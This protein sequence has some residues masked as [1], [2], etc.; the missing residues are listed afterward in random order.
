MSLPCVRRGKWSVPYLVWGAGSGVSLPCVR[1]GKGGVPYLVWG[2][3]SGVSPTLC[4]EGEVVCPPP[5]PASYSSSVP[6]DNTLK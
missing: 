2:R 6:S 3:G 5:F 1:R 4:G